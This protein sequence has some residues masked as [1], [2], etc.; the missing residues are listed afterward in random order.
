MKVRV[1]V[2]VKVKNTWSGGGVRSRLRTMPM[3]NEHQWKRSEDGLMEGDRP[4]AVGN[5]ATGRSGKEASK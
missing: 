2:N 5:G 3:K 1:K 4:G